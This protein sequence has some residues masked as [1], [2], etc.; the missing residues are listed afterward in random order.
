MTLLSKVVSSLIRFTKY[1]IYFKRFFLKKF[2]LLELKL[3]FA[4]VDLNNNALNTKK[5]I[6][7][8]LYA[9]FLIQIF[10]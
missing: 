4:C 8:N 1:G 3:N 2:D 5:K 9:P 6:K 10:F 7:L